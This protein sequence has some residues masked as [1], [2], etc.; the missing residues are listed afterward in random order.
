MENKEWERLLKINRGENWVA[1]NYS[2]DLI[3]HDLP[4]GVIYIENA[5]PNSKDF[6]N[7]IEKEND[8]NQIHSVIPPWSKWVDGYPV[9]LDPNDDT[10]WDHVFPE[11]ESAHRGLFKNLDWDETINNKNSIWPRKEVDENYSEAHKLAEPIYKLIE[12]DLFK[13]LKIWR[14][15]TG[16]E[17]SIWV[18]RNYCIRKYRTGGDL[19]VHIDRN[20]ENP[21]NTMDWTALIYLND[22]YTGGELVVNDYGYCIQPKAGSVVILPCLLVHSVKPVLSGTKTYIFLFMHTERNIVTA[23]GEP[24]QELNKL[25]DAA[26]LV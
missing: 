9:R 4:G 7:R 25:I 3:V 16:S 14:E 8:N 6:L 22:D 11:E 13:A 24:Y 20:I 10:K 2:G 5:F 18:T 17:E 23:L 19:G 1:P 26:N 12:P 21:L 15:K